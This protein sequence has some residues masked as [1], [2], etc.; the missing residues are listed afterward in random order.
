MDVGYRKFNFTSDVIQDSSFDECDLKES[1]FK[2]CRL[3]RTQ[4]ITF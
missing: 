3:E 1:S 2:G 4:Y